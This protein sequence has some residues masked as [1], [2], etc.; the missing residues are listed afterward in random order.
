M[1]HIAIVIAIFVGTT[2]HDIELSFIITGIMIGAAIGTIIALKIQMTSIPQMVA[3]FNGFGG[4]ASALIATA[5]FYKFNV[6]AAFEQC[7]QLVRTILA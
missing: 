3:A 2:K 7:M 6:Q 1:T 4:A 5:E